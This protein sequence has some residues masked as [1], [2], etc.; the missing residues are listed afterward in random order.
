VSAPGR[1]RFVAKGVADWPRSPYVRS[2]DAASHTL[3]T[4][5]AAK[6]RAR[7]RARAPRLVLWLALRRRGLRTRGRAGVDRP[8]AIFRTQRS[9]GRTRQ[10]GAPGRDVRRALAFG[11]ALPRG[12]PPGSVARRGAIRPRRVPAARPACRRGCGAAAARRQR[13]RT[14]LRRAVFC[15]LRGGWRPAP[16][17][18]GARF[19]FRRRPALRGANLARH[20]GAP[21]CARSAARTRLRPR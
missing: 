16:R 6:N 11:G 3:G 14:S 2:H 12:V 5:R 15:A 18:R 19:H 9:A 10:H 17:A 21:V 7:S 13:C 4:E 1:R 8:R 20:P